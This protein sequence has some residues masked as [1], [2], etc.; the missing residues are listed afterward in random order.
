MHSNYKESTSISVGC[1]TTFSGGTQAR[2]LGVM[3]S[4]PVHAADQLLH[5]SL[6][7]S[8]SGCSGS[9]PSVDYSSRLPSGF[10]TSGLIPYLILLEFILPPYHISSYSEMSKMQILTWAFQC[11]TSF[12]PFIAPHDLGQTQVSQNGISV[13]QDLALLLL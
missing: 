5:S 6:L 11:L 1:T 2:Y 8:C 12:H 4:P 9:G 13:L 7:Q 3:L 10:P